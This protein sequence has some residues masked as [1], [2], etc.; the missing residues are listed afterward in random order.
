M[1]PSQKQ[2]R[3]QFRI[4]REFLEQDACMYSIVDFADVQK[5]WCKGV[6][7]GIGDGRVMVSKAGAVYSLDPSSASKRIH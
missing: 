5:D 7:V 4:G 2:P 1:E 3:G 6:F